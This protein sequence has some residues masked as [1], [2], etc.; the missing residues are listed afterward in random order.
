MPGT[1]LLTE[2]S[3]L[4]SPSTPAEFQTSLPQRMVWKIGLARWWTA[5]TCTTGRGATFA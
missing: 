3:T 5:R 1:C 4:A 2:A